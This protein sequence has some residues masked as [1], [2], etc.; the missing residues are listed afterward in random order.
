MN[1]IKRFCLLAHAYCCCASPSILQVGK[2]VNLDRVLQQVI[3]G[4]LKGFLLFPGPGM[5][6][7]QTCVWYHVL[8]ASFPYLTLIVRIM[9]AIPLSA[10]T[11][12]QQVEMCDCAAAGSQDL[13]AA[14]LA[15]RQDPCLRCW[16][17]CS[18]GAS[19]LTSPPQRTTQQAQQGGI[20]QLHSN[21]QHPNSGHAAPTSGA[22]ATSIQTG[23]TAY[24][25]SQ[26]SPSSSA[27]A[28]ATDCALPTL[29]RVQQHICAET[30]RKQSNGHP[31]YVL[32]AIDGTWQEAKE[33][34]KVHIAFKMTTALTVCGLSH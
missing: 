11:Q 21:T 10:D 25:R 4:T 18:T 28:S 24:L 2:H 20:T 14:V 6:G 30:D 33:I 8:T 7:V 13:N 32:F 3:A 26:E 22:P 27:S 1:L 5:A 17:H 31:Q 34:Y 9:K 19:V 29:E 12:G 16:P 15:I 23:P